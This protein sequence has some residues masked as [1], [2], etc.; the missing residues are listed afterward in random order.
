V[1][2]ALSGFY[3]DVEHSTVITTGTWM[4]GEDITDQSG[5]DR[6]PTA[7]ELLDAVD[8]D[9]HPLGRRENWPDAL[10]MGLDLILS[11]RESMYLVW[12]NGLHLFFNDAYAPLLGP[13]LRHAMGR[14]FDDVWADAYQAVQP[15][16]DGALAGTPWRGVD[17][18]LRLARRGEPEDTWWTFSYTPL[19]DASGAVVAVLCIT[20]EMTEQVLARRAMREGEA[21]NRQIL[22]SA[23]D[24]AIIATSPEGRVTRWNAG[25]ARILGWTE[26]EMLGQTA[27]R[28]FTPEDRAEGRPQKEMREA[29][30]SGRATNERWHLMKDGRRFWGSGAMMP[31]EDAHGE[32]DGYVKVMRDQTA[33]RLREQR[34]TLLAQVAAGLLD[35]RDTDDVLGPVLE[36]SAE[37]MG[38]D[39]SFSYIVTPDGTHLHLSHAVGISDEERARL[40]KVSFDSRICGIVARSGKP[41]ILNNLQDTTDPRYEHGRASGYG[42]FAAFPMLTTDKLH[43]VMSFAIRGKNAFDDEALAFFATL[44]RY[45][46]VVRARLEN[47]AALSESQQHLLALNETLEQRVEATIAERELAQSALRQSQKM[48]AMGQLTGGVAHDFNNLLTPIIGSLDLLQRRGGHSAREARLIDSA[49]QSAERAKTLVQRLLAFAR[50]QPLQAGAVDVARLMEGMVDLIDSTSGPQLQITT[51]IEDNLPPALVDANQLE[52]AVLNL[53]VNA[54]DAMPEGGTLTIA[55]SLEPA[56]EPFGG[57]PRGT[58]FIR[59]SVIDTGIGMDAETVK[60]SIEPFFSTKGIGKGTG[61]GLSMVH[62]LASQLGGAMTIRSA[63]GAGTRIDL[64]LPL[65]LD[66]A[67]APAV[68]VDGTPGGSGSGR[69]LVVDDEELVRMTT[70]DMLQSIGYE[71]VEVASAAEAERLLREGEVFHLVVTDHLMPGMSGAQ[72]AEVIRRD[73]PAVPVLI[74]SGYADVGGI[75]SGFSRLTKPFREADLAQAI[76]AMTEPSRTLTA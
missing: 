54:R 58:P 73:W 49:L 45:V 25:A 10:R 21:R 6:P 11:S 34:L 56:P 30:E 64:W 57:K 51:K 53:A 15:Y 35:A 65:S 14:R 61:L 37:I 29:R 46:A 68:A 40:G 9:G 48:E 23:T 43:G 17:V 50:R 38:F 75:A 32:L 42:A 4:A 60:R 72:L 76:A 16:L 47:Q 22:D 18:P 3:D 13:R 55:A 62:G 74:I 63:P 69:V 41:L 20:N 31:L 71:T 44:V 27:E 66:P 36:Q 28:I 8:W 26:E 39:E 24:Y 1:T 12:G 59:L 2:G 19:T 52:M 5:A 70:A 33:G 67:D 7:Y